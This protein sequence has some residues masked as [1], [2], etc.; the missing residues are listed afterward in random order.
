MPATEPLLMDLDEC[1]RLAAGI[2]YP[3]ILKAGWGG[4]NRG[5]RVLENEQDLEPSLAAARL[6]DEVM[7]EAMSLRGI[8]RPAESPGRAL[9]RSLRRASGEESTQIAHE[10]EK[11]PRVAAGDARPTD[12]T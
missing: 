1:K 11:R 6:E 4:R 9:G 3:L 8:S 2:G 5:L 12:M 7:P 10:G